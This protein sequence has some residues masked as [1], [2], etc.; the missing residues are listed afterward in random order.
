[1]IVGDLL[2]ALGSDQL[3]AKSQAYIT[4]ALHRKGSGELDEYQLWASL[5]LEL[6]GKA[7]LSSIHPSLIVDPTHYPSLFAAARVN[8]TTDVKTIGAHTLFERLRH[9]SARFDERVRGFCNS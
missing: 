3:Y 6:L 5:A 9:L 2:P 4:R 7:A 8:F 1:M